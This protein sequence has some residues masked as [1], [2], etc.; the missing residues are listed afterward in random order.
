MF[1]PLAAGFGG[2]VGFGGVMLG[3]VTLQFGG[4]GS[5]PPT[6][7]GVAHVPE[8]LSHINRTAPGTVT[9]L[10]EPHCQASTGTAQEQHMPIDDR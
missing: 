5:V 7:P 10:P 9:Q 8:P 4:G 3:V 6:G 2:A 1:G